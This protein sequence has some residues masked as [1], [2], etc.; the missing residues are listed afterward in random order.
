MKVI[1]FLLEAL[2]N[3]TILCLKILVALIG[4]FLGASAANSTGEESEAEGEVGLNATTQAMELKN[5]NDLY[6]NNEK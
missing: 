1:N 2:I 5:I 6:L 4:A 3:I